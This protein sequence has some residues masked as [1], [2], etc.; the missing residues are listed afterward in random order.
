LNPI[1]L[2]QFNAFIGSKLQECTSHDLRRLYGVLSYQMWAP[3]TNL[4]LWLNRVLGHSAD[5]IQSSFH[6][7]MFRVELNKSDWKSDVGPPP[8]TQPPSTQPPSTQPPSTQPPSTATL[9]FPTVHRKMTSEERWQ[10]IRDAIR[11]MQENHIPVSAKKLQVYC[12][13]SSSWAANAMQW[14]WS[15]MK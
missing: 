1:L 10:V 5:S 9:S 4:N 15:T 7:S 2:A 14:Y 8:S 3:D 6:Y 11:I 13:M 12:K